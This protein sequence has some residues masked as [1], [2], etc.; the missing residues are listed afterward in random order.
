MNKTII[1][2]RISCAEINFC[3]GRRRALFY[4]SRKQKPGQQRHERAEPAYYSS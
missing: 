1:N 4:Q 2:L 3:L